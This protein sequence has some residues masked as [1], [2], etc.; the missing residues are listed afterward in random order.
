MSTAVLMCWFTSIWT[1]H[2]FSPT[3]SGSLVG[4]TLTRVGA[5]TAPCFSGMSAA[6]PSTW[7]A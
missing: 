4:I 1:S 6:I 5:S 2:R 3:S 7:R